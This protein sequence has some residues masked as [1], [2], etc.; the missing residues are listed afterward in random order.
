M[1]S[2]CP[3]TSRHSL[4]RHG[5]IGRA[6]RNRPC[7]LPSCVIGGQKKADVTAHLTVFGHV[8]LLV[9]GLPDSAGLPFI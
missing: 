2:S 5:C 4:L 6:H 7:S 1:S 8:G 9:N 3:K